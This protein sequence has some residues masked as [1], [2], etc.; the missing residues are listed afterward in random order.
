MSEQLDAIDFAVAAYHEEGDWQVAEIADH[1]LVDVDAVAAALRRF[2]SDGGALAMIAVDEDFFILVRAVGTSVRVVLSDVTAAEE[3]ELAQSALDRLHLP[4]PDDEE[5]PA[6]AG[7]LDLLTDLGLGARDLGELLDDE[8]L[9][10]DEALSYVARR[11][12]F[13]DSFDAAVG[14]T[15]A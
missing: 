7:E 14:L 11:L 9:Y 5:D 10:P 3:W 6:P 2:P 8:D 1:Y 4:T 12:G 15:S 13:G